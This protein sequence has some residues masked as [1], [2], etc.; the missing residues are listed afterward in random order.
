MFQLGVSEFQVLELEQDS[1]AEPHCVL[2]VFEGP[3]RMSRVEFGREGVDMGRDPT[4]SF[5]IPEDS[6]MSNRHARVGFQAGR[7]LLSDLGST[8]K[9]VPRC[10]LNIRTWVRLS[11]EGQKSLPREIVSGDIIKIGSSVFIVESQKGSSE[12]AETHV[13]EVEKTAGGTEGSLCKICYSNEANGVFIPCGH[14]FTCYRCA[15]KCTECP[16]C[17]K[18]IEDVIRIFKS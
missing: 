11:P 14:N 9:S 2:H 18:G 7:F 15:K 5:S 16:M 10:D 13:P 3:G 4:C 12:P 6:Q 17:R 8:N 1:Q